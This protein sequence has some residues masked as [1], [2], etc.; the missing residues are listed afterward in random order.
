MEQR[1]IALKKGSKRPNI[2]VPKEMKE[3]IELYKTGKPF[4]YE[5]RLAPHE[6]IDIKPKEIAELKKEVEIVESKKMLFPFLPEIFVDMEKIAVGKF[7]KK[8]TPTV[9][10]THSSRI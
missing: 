7:G 5:I 8:N 9:A 1:A 3:Y 2:R 4:E 6:E 10:Q